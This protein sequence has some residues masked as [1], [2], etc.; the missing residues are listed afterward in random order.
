MVATEH[1]IAQVWFEH[2]SP[3]FFST[4]RMFSMAFLFAVW[5]GRG[6]RS[7]ILAGF[8]VGVSIM[9]SVFVCESQTRHNMEGFAGTNMRAIGSNRGAIGAFHFVVQYAV[10]VILGA[11][12]GALHSAIAERYT[13]TGGKSGWMTIDVRTAKRS[14]GIDPETVSLSLLICQLALASWV[15]AFMGV[16]GEALSAMFPHNLLPVGW[17]VLL[18]VPLAITFLAAYVVFPFGDGSVMHSSD[19]VKNFAGTSDSARKSTPGVV[20]PYVVWPLVVIGAY[21]TVIYI[22][23]TCWWATNG[24]RVRWAATDSELS[25]LLVDSAVFRTVVVSSATALVLVAESIACYTNDIS[26]SDVRGAFY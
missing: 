10:V 15:F 1:L 22:C 6:G 23:N 9:V 17:T 3:D 21:L 7:A 4:W 16:T 19:P 12:C 14:V 2:D 24:T 13:T 18:F 25:G 20:I 8:F 5:S 11:I 26:L